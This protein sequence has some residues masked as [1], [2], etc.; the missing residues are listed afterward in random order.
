MMKIEVS[1][2]AFSDCILLYRFVSDVL[3]IVV[4]LSNYSDK[5]ILIV[6]RLAEKKMTR[7]Q[8]TPPNG[9]HRSPVIGDKLAL[10]HARKGVVGLVLEEEKMPFTESGITPDL[11]INPHSI[12]SRMTVGQVIEAMVGVEFL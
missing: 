2:G 1:S 8:T 9:I 10:R 6:E 11:I 5:E 7:V 4:V 12:P 3:F